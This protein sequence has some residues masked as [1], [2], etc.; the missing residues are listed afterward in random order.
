MTF[1]LTDTP[2]IYYDAERVVFT[3]EDETSNFCE[4]YICKGEAVAA[5][6]R[7]VKYLKYLN[8]GIE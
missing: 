6:D 4:E 1:K 3:Y 2:H 5:L 7:Y 8:K